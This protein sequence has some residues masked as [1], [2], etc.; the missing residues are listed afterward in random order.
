MERAAARV[1]EIEG[2]VGERKLAIDEVATHQRRLES[3][4]DSLGMKA[5]AE[6][7]RQYDGSVANPKELQ[8]IEA[9]VTSIRNRI[10]VKEDELLEIMERREE[11]ESGLPAL[12]AELEAARAGM[13]EIES[14]VG[15]GLAEVQRGLDEG[16]AEREALAGSIDPDVLGLYE[17]LRRQKK[18]V[19]AAALVDGVCQGCHQKL[20]PVYLERLKH[21]KGV[22]RCEYCRRILVTG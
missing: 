12:E 11:L 2:R 10:S 6:R 16:R 17:D 1:R 13:T 14:S 15:E 3:D 5:D 8:S 21:E 20:S 18:G 22:R 9:E 7:R 19:G 4:I